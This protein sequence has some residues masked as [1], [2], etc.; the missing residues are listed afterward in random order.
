MAKSVSSCRSRRLLYTD[1]RLNGNIVRLHN[2]DWKQTILKHI[3]YHVWK[4]GGIKQKQQTEDRGSLHPN[5]GSYFFFLYM[6]LLMLY[7]LC[8]SLSPR[9]KIH[10]FSKKWLKEQK[11]FPR[12]CS[13][14]FFCLNHVWVHPSLFA[15][16]NQNAV[17]GKPPIHKHIIT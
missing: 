9:I 6:G 5:G 2:K 12:L 10:R 8:L 4:K 14:W 7:A 16:R 3:Y 1:H 11:C 17:I 13:T 15:P